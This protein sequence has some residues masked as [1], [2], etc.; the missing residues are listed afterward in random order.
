MSFIESFNVEENE[1]QFWK[2]LNKKQAGRSG[3]KIIETYDGKFI[4][5]EITNEE[6]QL[7]VSISKEYSKH[8]TSQQE[9]MLSKIFGFFTLKKVTKDEEITKSHFIVMEN[10]DMFQ[11]G[12]VKF[13][14]DLKFSEYNRQS[15]DLPSDAQ[16][17][18][19]LYLSMDE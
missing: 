14:Y 1:E 19:D 2:E 6:K 18:R 17:I 8:V 4:V 5:K 13:K 10:L 16:K 15:L 7:L 11:E 12:S 9:T 3:K